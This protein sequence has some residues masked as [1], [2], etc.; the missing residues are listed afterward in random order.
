[1][2]GGTL[3]RRGGGVKTWVCGA[4][5][6]A[7]AVLVRMYVKDVSRSSAGRVAT[8]SDTLLI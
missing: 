1:M 4:V 8:T 2:D 5:L 7:L 3:L 6:V